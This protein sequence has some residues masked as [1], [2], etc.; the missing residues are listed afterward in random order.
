[1][2]DVEGVSVALG[3]AD[4]L[5]VPLGESVAEGVPLRVRLSEA[6]AL[7]LG[8]PVGLGVPVVLG[9]PV[10]LGVRDPDTVC[11]CDVDAVPV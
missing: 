5:C 9:L 10:L 7:A 6:V 3:V 2:S 8:L 1:M 11:V 4:P